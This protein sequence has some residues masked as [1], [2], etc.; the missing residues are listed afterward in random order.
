MK[1]KKLWF[2]AV[3][4]VFLL[5]GCMNTN[6]KDTGEVS[7]KPVKVIEIR[8][9]QGT[10]ELSYNGVVKPEEIKKI[11]FKA[12]GKIASIKV[13]KGQKVKKGDILAALDTKE[14]SFAVEAARAA[15]TGAMAQYQK[16]LNG[17]AMEDIDL[18][19]S[20]V[21]KAQKAHEFAKDSL[22]KI[23]KLYDEGAA[24]KQD[25]D[26]VVLEYEIRNQ[27]YLG[28]KTILQQ[29]TNGAREEDKEALK[30]Q[31]TQADVDLRYKESAVNDATLKADAEGYVMD[32]LSEEGEMISAGYPIIILGSHSNVVS[33]GLNQEDASTVKIGD[34]IRIESQDSSYTGKIKSIAKNMDMETRTYDAEVLLDNNFLP[35]GS[36]LKVFIPKEQYNA[37]I[38]PIVSILRGNYDYVYV[39]D[40]GIA[41]K[42]QIKLGY[43]HEDMVEVTGLFQG[44]KLVL[45]G[46]K[47][48][49]DGDIVE[50]IQ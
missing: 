49:N 4:S 36:I 20:N 30:S 13:E 42:K 11:S 33:F 23:Q 45:E 7:K 29:V 50:I 47:S 17:A 31:M 27:E 16:S 6:D 43:I 35:S 22:D 28:A 19:S 25:L 44:D 21:T 40:N 5:I 46:M 3:F 34:S 32:I 38:I 48:I 10:K 12:S 1:N 8:E 26:K 18:A 15:K 9:T 14:L 2:I 39:I 24:S 41:R 37:I